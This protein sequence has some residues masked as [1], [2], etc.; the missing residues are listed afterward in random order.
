MLF[1]ASEKYIE[2]HMIYELIGNMKQYEK[3]YKQHM[4]ICFINENIGK[5]EKWNN[6]RKKSL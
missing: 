2:T 6:P 5:S 3:T 4:L 1:P